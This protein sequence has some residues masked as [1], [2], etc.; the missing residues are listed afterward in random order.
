VSQDLSSTFA[1]VAALILK[2]RQ[3][4]YVAVNSAHIDLCWQ[5]GAYISAKIEAA[6]WGEKAVDGL[7]S[8]LAERHPDLKGFTRASLFRMRQFFEAY[9]EGGEIIAP[10]V[11][12]LP[13]THNLVILGRCKSMQERRFYLEK[14][15]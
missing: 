12:Q 3:R 11:R 6:T 4:A 5:V 9:R 14:A 8:Y 10:Q 2:A 15:A 7:A 13:W 1:E